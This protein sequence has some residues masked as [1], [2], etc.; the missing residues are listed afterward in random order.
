MRPIED[1]KP[2]PQIGPGM[3]QEF[4]VGN[5]VRLDSRFSM[6]LDWEEAKSKQSNRQKRIYRIWPECLGF[7]VV[8]VT[9]G[10]SAWLTWRK[11]PD[12]LVDFGEQL[13]LPWRIS[14]GSVLYR[15]V[16]YLTGGPL[17]QY[18]HAGLFKL[19]GVSFLTLIISNLAIGL[20]LLLLM[21]RRFVECADALTSTTICVGVILVLA[22]GQYS[23]IGNY[24]FVTP[25]C[26]KVWHKMVLSILAISFLAS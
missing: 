25:Y 26:H 8:I 13:Y 9:Y 5:D 20:G 22:F 18:Y 15:D 4:P 12:L 14:V 1:K 2:E 24:N 21:Y 16:M 6:V 10:L 3:V 7:V 17:S 23:D 19:F 11:W